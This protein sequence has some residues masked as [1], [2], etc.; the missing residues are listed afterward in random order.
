ME[1]VSIIDGVCVLWRR[2]DI[3]ASVKD[4]T[5]LSIS[6]HPETSLSQGNLCVK[7]KY[8]YEFVRLLIRLKNPRI[9]KSFLEK[10]SYRN[11]LY[12]KSIR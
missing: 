11:F 4:N 6:A 5:I 1:N 3:R 12:L 10:P 9:R 7:V 8:E 2:H